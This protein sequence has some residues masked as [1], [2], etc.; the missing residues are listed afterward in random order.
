MGLIDR[1]AVKR[2]AGK[3]AKQPW[4]E[5]RFGGDIEQL[6]LAVAHTGHVL[7]VFFKR[8]RTVKT[9]RRNTQLAQLLQ[10]IFH[11][12]NQ[13]GDDHRQTSE[14]QRRDLVTQ[15]FAP[16]RGHDHQRVAPL[17]NILDDLA[18]EGF[19]LIVA[20]DTFAKLI[21]IRNC[22]HAEIIRV[23]RRV[24]VWAPKYLPH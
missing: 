1:Q 11:Q 3:Q 17:Q 6:D 19:E 24:R 21:R 15:R 13:R 2:Q 12:G 10:L 22:H 7:L 8:Q 5:Q 23:F 4:G 16:A 20:K 18:L 14:D 9:K